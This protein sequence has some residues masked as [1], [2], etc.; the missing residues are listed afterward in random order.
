MSTVPSFLFLFEIKKLTFRSS[1]LFL[2]IFFLSFL[3]FSFPFEVGTGGKQSFLE[4][5]VSKKKKKK[6]TRK[7]GT[8]TYKN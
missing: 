5:I 6:K 7:D 3:R 1:R 2:K 8:Y 4:K